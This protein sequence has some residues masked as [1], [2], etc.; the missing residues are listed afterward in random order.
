MMSDSRARK[1]SA[2]ARS[3]AKVSALLPPHRGQCQGAGTP[4]RFG[5]RRRGRPPLLCR[6][7]N[8]RTRFA[9]GR[10]SGPEAVHCGVLLNSLPDPAPSLFTG[11]C[12]HS[13]RPIVPIRLIGPKLL[14]PIDGSTGSPHRAEHFFPRYAYYPC[15]VAPLT[16]LIPAQSSDLPFRQPTIAS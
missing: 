12:S 2:M 7:R 5:V 8:S 11:G 4:R 13:N 1:N 14:P 15:G 6:R 9:T 3:S 16:Y 10:R